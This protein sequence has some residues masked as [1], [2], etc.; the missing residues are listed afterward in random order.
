[1]ILRADKIKVSN[2]L[3]NLYLENFIT[4]TSRGHYIA[5]DL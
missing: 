3:Q 1:M 4:R 5:A 2:I